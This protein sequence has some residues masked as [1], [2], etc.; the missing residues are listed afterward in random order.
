MKKL[1]LLIIMHLFSSCFLFSQVGVSNDNST[2]DNSAILDVKSTSKGVLIPRM[3]LEQRN[4]IE[5]PASGLMVFCTDCGTNG[6]ISVFS[7]EA[8]RTY[9]PCEINSPSVGSHTALPYQV[10]WNWNTVPGASGYKWNTTNDYITATDM[11]S[12]TSKTEINLTCNT[13]YTRYA[14]AYNFCGFSTPVAL[15][16]TTL[17]CYTCGSSMIINHV[18]GSVA[19]V[20]KTVTYGLV[21]GIPGETSKCWITSNL[22]ADNQATAVNDATEASAGW[23]WQFN[24]MQGYKH[25]GTTVTPAWTI[26]EINEDINWQAASDPCSLELGSGWRLP[27]KTEWTNVDASGGWAEWNGPWNSDLKLHAAGYINCYDAQLVDRGYSGLYWSSSTEPGYGESGWHLHFYNSN[28]YINSNMK[29]LG[30]TIRC[31]HD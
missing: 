4:A 17:E 26:T 10:V 9:F 29:A 7:N 25:N 30:F 31:L 12:A 13:S 16:K 19:P 27:T 24:R 28:S 23:Y 1:S 3:S 6:A 15:T 14:W 22:G 5:N 11:G 20:T 2:P 21:T 8:W 18:A